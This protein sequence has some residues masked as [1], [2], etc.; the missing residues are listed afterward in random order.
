L[1]DR[2]VATRAILLEQDKDPDTRIRLALDGLAE[3]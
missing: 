3:H 1:N 2:L